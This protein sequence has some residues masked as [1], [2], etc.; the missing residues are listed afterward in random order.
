MENKYIFRNVSRSLIIFCFVVLAIVWY[1]DIDFNKKTNISTFV[2]VVFTF[3][4]ITL[5]MNRRVKIGK[6]LVDPNSKI[7][8]VYR[9]NDGSFWLKL[10]G[11]KKIKTKLRIFFGTLKCVS[12]KLLLHINSQRRWGGKRCS[13]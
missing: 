9:R 8:P 11:E 6:I 12:V 4:V 10:D 1:G 3:A 2:F 13:C 5:Y 7:K